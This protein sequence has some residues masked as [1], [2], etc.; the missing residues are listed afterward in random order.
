MKWSIGTSALCA[1]TTRAAGKYFRVPAT[2]G[3]LNPPTLLK[4]ISNMKKKYFNIFEV[5]IKLFQK[6][7]LKDG[8][9]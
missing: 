3:W 9:T 6:S 5:F 8:L 1:E 2:S 7:Y 4:S